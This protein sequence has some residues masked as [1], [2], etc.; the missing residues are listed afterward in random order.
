VVH[1][2][3]RQAWI[4]RL[5][6]IDQEQLWRRAHELQ[7]A[8]HRLG[9][10]A[11]GLSAAARRL[12]GDIEAAHAAVE[13]AERRVVSVRFPGRSGP[14]KRELERALG[15][16]QEVLQRAGFDSWLGFQ[17]RRLDALVDPDTIEDTQAAKADWDRAVV[18]W[19]AVA[20]GVDVVE[21]LAAQAEIEALSGRRVDVVL[22]DVEHTES[23]E[24][25]V[26]S[27]SDVA[28]A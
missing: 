27:R 28:K 21:A 23:A 26:L 9:E 4:Q 15:A 14:A 5:A 22:E 10:L 7:Q 19:R 18:A 1:T 12:M 2:W 13:A 20:P 11:F 17:L 16:E 24:P 8:E 6:A 3:K 25:Q